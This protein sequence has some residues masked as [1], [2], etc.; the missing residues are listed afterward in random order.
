MSPTIQLRRVA[1]RT[2]GPIR[3]V[4]AETFG[5]WDPDALAPSNYVTA[6]ARE[7]YD[8]LGVPTDDSSY[9]LCSARD[10]SGRW[11]LIGKILQGHEWAVEVRS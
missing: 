8:V 4:N 5:E 9:T 2:W 3:D 10:G 6:R 11:A 7:L 1:V